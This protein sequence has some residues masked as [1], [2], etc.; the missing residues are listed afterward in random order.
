MGRI[1]KAEVAAI[2][3]AHL[4][5]PLA[6]APDVGFTMGGT[7]WIG[8]GGN[9]WFYQGLRAHAAYCKGRNVRLIAEREHGMRRALFARLWRQV[10]KE[11]IAAGARCV[12]V[13]VI[14]G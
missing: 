10:V 11:L 5:I 8:G 13:K 12:H 14:G 9:P 7:R 1:S 4:G 6:M 2:H 3:A